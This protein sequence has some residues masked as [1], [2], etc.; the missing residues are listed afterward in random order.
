MEYVI[1]ALYVIAS[2][3]IAR[4]IGRKRKIGYGKSVLI[5]VLFSPVIGLICTLSS[6]KIDNFTYQ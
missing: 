2:H 4:Y 6:K 3:L 5:S 1:I